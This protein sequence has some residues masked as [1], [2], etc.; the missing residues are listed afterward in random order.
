MK[1]KICL[2]VAF[3]LC[4]I[5]SMA[6]PSVYGFGNESDSAAIKRNQKNIAYLKHQLSAQKERL[7]GLMSVVEGLSATLNEYQHKSAV[8]GE[9]HSDAKSRDD[10]LRELGKMIDHINATYVSKA[11]LKKMLLEE[12]G[13]SDVAKK[14]SKPIV[15]HAENLDQKSISSIY[16]E[17]VRLFQKKR[18]EEAKKRFEITDTKGYKPAA[19]NYYLGE[20]AYY[21][22]KYDDAIFYF[23]KSAGLYDK[24]GYIDVLLLHTAI[25]LEKTGDKPQA[26]LFY[27]NIIANYPQRNSAKIA[28]NRINT[29]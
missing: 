6:E 12:K 4:T 19:S 2:P 9:S 14:K 23:K 17:G 22:K 5:A 16:S 29:L 15:D 24:A 8:A 1:C 18:Y 11:E 20:I 26:K 25:A 3:F 10:L 13:Y 21:T 7:D 28:K 27:E